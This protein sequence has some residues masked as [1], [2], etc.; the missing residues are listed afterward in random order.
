M[1]RYI[2]AWVMLF[3]PKSSY[4][5]VTRTITI[6][7]CFFLAVTS[8]LPVT[9]C[10][11]EI[12]ERVVAYVNN[13]AITLSEFRENA[14]IMR[15]KSGNISDPDIINAMINRILLLHEAK[16]L[17]LEA[18]DEDE[19]VQDYIDIKIKSA[20]LIKEEAIESFYSENAAKFEGRDYLAVRDEIEKYLFEREVNKRLKEHIE[21]LRAGADIKIQLQEQGQAASSEFLSVPFRLQAE[22]YRVLIALRE[23]V[24]LAAVF[25]DPVGEFCPVYFFKT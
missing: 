9:N 2:S 18:A 5:R 24:A 10:Y 11:A 8:L 20:I 19:L 25:P 14:V 7:V 16:K 22:N 1:V 6:L 12:L 4:N 23:F 13:T 15:K 17:R 21:E 3:S